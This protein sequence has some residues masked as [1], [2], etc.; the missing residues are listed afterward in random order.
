MP[1]QI[2]NS[3]NQEIEDSNKDEA[4]E[5]PTNPLDKTMSR[6]SFLK[7]AL[8]A[9]GAT[10][11]TACNRDEIFPAEKQNSLTENKRKFND[12]FSQIEGMYLNP[13]GNFD[14]DR[15]KT[16]PEFERYITEI[17]T[18]SEK[19][20]QALG[21]NPNALKLL[22]S[23]I[24]AA[25]LGNWENINTNQP[26]NTV[27][28]R[29]GPMQFYTTQA[30]D[31][32]RS[33]LKDNYNYT[34]SEINGVF[35]IQIGMN[36]LVY[37][38]LSNVDLKSGGNAIEL[39]LAQYYGGEDLVDHIRANRAVAEGSFLREGYDRYQRTV[40]VINSAKAPKAKVEAAEGGSIEASLNEI[41]NKAV[42][43]W[44][45]TN[46]EKAKTYL[47]REAKRYAGDP[48]PE[49][50]GLSPKEY[51]AAFISIVMTESNGGIN[52]ETNPKS[53]AKGWFQVVPRFHLR[54]YNQ[55]VGLPQGHLY[56]EDDLLN[57]VEASIKVGAW[58]LMRYRN[59]AGY[60]DMKE[61][62]KVFKGGWYFPSEWDDGIWWNRV[63]YCTSNLFSHDRFGMGYIDYQLPEGIHRKAEEFLANEEHIGNVR[64]R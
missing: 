30:L 19:M 23:S 9:A 1:E 40:Q 53:G 27:R 31:T 45:N 4:P 3:P 51:L 47:Y 29:I 25:N 8:V 28:E 16:N 36:Y 63:S 22:T 11:L 32:L 35:N 33:Q 58:A 49:V 59:A 18:N 50:L 6:R 17:H 24:I 56:T 43:F 7:L 15:F 44:P 55:Q 64:I 61:L 41:W 60:Q 14:Y 26:P 37:N 48:Y 42:A 21:I 5:A 12:Q 46:L 10:A 38:A 54:E 52:T 13:D 62:M 57:N 20:G 2:Y 39:T 34:T